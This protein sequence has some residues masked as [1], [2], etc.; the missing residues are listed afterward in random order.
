V[1][2]SSDTGNATSDTGNAVSD[3]GN[4]ASDT[5]NAAS[6]TANAASERATR[7]FEFGAGSSE[8][9]FPNYKHSLTGTDTSARRSMQL[10][11][12]CN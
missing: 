4:A 8:S 9:S 6:D 2:T 7:R 11:A 10:V 12:E 1:R 3:T 5:A